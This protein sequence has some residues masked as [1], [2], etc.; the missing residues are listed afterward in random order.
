M[1]VDKIIQITAGTEGEHPGGIG[2]SVYGLSEN[3]NLYA[4]VNNKWIFVCSSPTR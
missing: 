2:H 4:H 3:G 1:S